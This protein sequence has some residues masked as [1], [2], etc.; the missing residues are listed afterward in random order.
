MREKEIQRRKVDNE[1][2]VINLA[3]T[4]TRKTLEMMQNTISFYLLNFYPLD[5]SVIGQRLLEERRCKFSALPFSLP[6]EPSRFSAVLQQKCRCWP[7][8]DSL[9]SRNGK[10]V[11]NK[12]SGALMCLL[13]Q[14]TGKNC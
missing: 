5:L 8:E 4:W 2:Y 12:R 14:P 1:G 9:P 6:C 3:P 11:Q 7:L 13:F 10:M